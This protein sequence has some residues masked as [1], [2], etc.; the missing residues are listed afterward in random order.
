MEG[1]GRPGV[2]EPA[3]CLIHWGVLWPVFATGE[4]GEGEVKGDPAG[5]QHLMSQDI[6]VNE[7]D[8]SGNTNALKKSALA[9]FLETPQSLDLPGPPIFTGVLA[10]LVVSFGNRVIDTLLCGSGRHEVTLLR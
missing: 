10:D 2:L 6:C 3:L 4:D 1:A 5:S 7:P 8:H 9:L